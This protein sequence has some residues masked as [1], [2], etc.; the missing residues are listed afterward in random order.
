MPTTDIEGVYTNF[1]VVV[2][3]IIYAYLLGALCKYACLLVLEPNEHLRVNILM[4]EPKDDARRR[5]VDDV[6]KPG[7]HR[8][9][10][11]VHV[12][13]RLMTQRALRSAREPSSLRTRKA[14]RLYERR[15][16]CKLGLSTNCER[17]PP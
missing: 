15:A 13:S 2:C 6:H 9:H 11:V 4:L 5:W 17:H 16:R 1:T 14:A 10:F 7:A 8:S 12:S 3:G